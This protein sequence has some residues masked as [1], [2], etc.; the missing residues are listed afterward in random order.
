[1]PRGCACPLSRGGGLQFRSRSG[2]LVA[3]VLP[4]GVLLFQGGPQDDDCPAIGQCLWPL[5]CC[6][7]SERDSW[8]PLVRKGPHATIWIEA[9]SLE[10]GS[11]EVLGRAEPREH[12]E[13]VRQTIL[14]GDEIE[15]VRAVEEAL[16]DG[17]AP[18]V[19][20]NEG[21]LNGAHEVGKGFEAGVLFLPELM[22]A[23]R[24]LKM[25]MAVLTARP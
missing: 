23:G 3:R 8:L 14:S 11:G 1:M 20:L 13:R 15:S 9:M 5:E 2:S 6:I 16:E 12:L 18:L 17:L 4:S 7:S 19:V 25:A 24:A 21:L 22:L 10:R